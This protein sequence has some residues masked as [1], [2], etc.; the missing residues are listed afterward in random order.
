MSLMLNKDASFSL[1]AYVSSPGYQSIVLRGYLVEK[2]NG[3]TW[4]AP[5]IPQLFYGVTGQQ[6]GPSWR[7]YFS[8]TGQQV[9]L[10][11]S[12]GKPEVPREELWWRKVAEA[13]KAAPTPTPTVT[14]IVLPTIPKWL[15]VVGIAALAIGAGVILWRR[16]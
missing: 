11:R 5:L 1:S 3:E 16:K 13:A 7:Q 14:T 6:L 10:S 4:I 9:I 12:G 15:I 2:R 8:T